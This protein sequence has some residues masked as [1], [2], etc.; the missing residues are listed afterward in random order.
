MVHYWLI[1]IAAVIVLVLV[2]QLLAQYNVISKKGRILVGVGLLVVALG[3]GVFTLFQE[4]NDSRL[5]ELAKLF[6]QGKTLVCV[7]GSE[8]LEV[9][10]EKFNFISGTLTLMGKESSEYFRKTIPLK[11]CELKNEKSH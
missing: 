11:A 2:V 4:K 10:K 7:V 6:L 8:S 3:I 5:T 1:V 9:D